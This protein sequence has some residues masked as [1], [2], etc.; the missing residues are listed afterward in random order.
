L[1]DNPTF[2]EV[3]PSG[4]SHGFENAAED[5]YSGLSADKDGFGAQDVELIID[6]GS[7]PP[8]VLPSSAMVTDG[9]TRPGRAVVV[10][11]SLAWSGLMAVIFTTVGALIPIPLFPLLFPGLVTGGIYGF[12]FGEPQHTDGWGVLPHPT[13]NGTAFL[14]GNLVAWVGITYLFLSWKSKRPKPS[15]RSDAPPHDLA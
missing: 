11:K 1:Y 7:F 2:E 9:M 6:D 13:I 3:A 4:S 14:V 8:A 10:L 5:N 15:Q 12:F